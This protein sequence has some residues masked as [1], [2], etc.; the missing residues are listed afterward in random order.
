MQVK[1]QNGYFYFSSEDKYSWN[2]PDPNDASLYEAMHT[3]RYNLNTLTQTQAYRIL[4]A[5][6][7][8]RHFTTHPA[9]NKQIFKQLALLRKAVKKADRGDR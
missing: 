8:Y 2:A 9:T 1:L 4:E 3:A 7:V 5:A 6:E